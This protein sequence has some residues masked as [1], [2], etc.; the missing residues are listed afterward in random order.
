MTGISFHFN[1]A[2]KVAYACRLLRKAVNGG[3]RVVVMGEPHALGQLDVALWTFSPLDFIPHC[4]HS[5]RESLVAA[6]PIVL[7]SLP[8]ASSTSP[9]QST[10]H[11]QVLLNLGTQVPEDFER[12]ER[13]IELVGV[14]DQDRQVARQRWKHYASRGYAI[15]RHDIATSTA[16]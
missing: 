12:F 4:F 16:H 6:S 11:T 2:D 5:D 7:V 8:P 14:D 1:A 9:M 15:T 10:A 13:L 3:A